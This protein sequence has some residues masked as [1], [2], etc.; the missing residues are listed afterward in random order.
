SGFN[1]PFAES[2]ALLSDG[3]TLAFMSGHGFGL[4]GQISGYATNKDGTPG[5]NP[6]SYML[7][8]GKKLVYGDQPSNAVFGIRPTRELPRLWLVTLPKKVVDY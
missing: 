7:A 2:M 4:E 6:A 5:L 3:R 1:E 8:E